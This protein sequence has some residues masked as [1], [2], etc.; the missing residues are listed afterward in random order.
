M[1]RLTIALLALATTNTA[2]AVTIDFESIDSYTAAPL[3]AQG[4]SEIQTNGFVFSAF[5]YMDYSGTLDGNSFLLTDAIHDAYPITMQA[6]SGEVF[7]LESLSGQ[8][9]GWNITG[10]YAGGGT[11]QTGLSVG[12]NAGTATK[13]N[14]ILGSEWQG[15]ESVTFE[16]NF[17]FFYSGLDDVV[18]S[19]V[20][21]PPAAWL[22]GSAL[23]GLGWLRRRQTA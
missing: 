10:R 13:T 23:T 11:I 9:G 8:L 22:F 17:E 20:P 6:I 21:V 14:L 18:V 1:L 3:G 5:A 4:A 2:F 15:L 19:T 16:A 12:A 7:A